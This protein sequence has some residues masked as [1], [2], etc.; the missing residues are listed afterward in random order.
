MRSRRI[1]GG[2]HLR[3]AGFGSAPRPQH[4]RWNDA[5]IRM[6][7]GV[8][9]MQNMKMTGDVD[10]D[11]AMMMAQH[12]ADGIKMADVEIRHGK[13][14]HLKNMAKKIKAA[15]TK[16]RADLLKHASMKH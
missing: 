14:A 7:D 1:R 5:P 3:L 15:Q 16:E 13:N 8:K 4:D 9:K 6:M 11:F 10:R 12:H 2:R